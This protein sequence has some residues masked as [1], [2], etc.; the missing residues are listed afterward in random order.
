VF[1]SVLG[2]LFQLI[3]IQKIG[4]PKTA[5]FINL[6]PVFTMLQAQLIL[7]ETVTWLQLVS[8]G[9]IIGGVYLTTSTVPIIKQSS[10]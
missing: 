6:V 10:T 7:G 8:A 2:Y 3:A 5:I 4:A 9:V 1:A